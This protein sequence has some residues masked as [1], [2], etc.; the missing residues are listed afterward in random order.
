MY[1]VAHLAPRSLPN[2]KWQPRLVLQLQRAT[3]KRILPAFDVVPAATILSLVRKT[4]RARELMARKLTPGPNDLVVFY[5][6]HNQPLAT[7]ADNMAAN[8]STPAR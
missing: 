2:L 6:D 1:H 7:E 8:M 3:A 4:T 5:A